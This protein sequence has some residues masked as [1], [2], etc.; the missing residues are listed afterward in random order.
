MT[1]SMRIL[2]LVAIASLGLL[3]MKSLSLTSDILSLFDPATAAWAS[4]SSAKKEKK[5]KNNDKKVDTHNAAPGP[6]LTYGEYGSSEHENGSGDLVCEGPSQAE[7]AGLSEQELNVYLTLGERNRLLNDR[8]SEI[9]TREGLLAV[10]QQQIDD[11][12]AKL[13]SLKTDIG[14]LLG[15]LDEQEEE[16]IQTLI[17]LYDAMKHKSAAQIFVGLDTNVLLQVASRIKS[18]NLAKIMAAMPPQKAGELTMA[19]A[20]RNRLPETAKDLPGFSGGEK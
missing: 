9:A 13:E 19:L 8:E 20:A 7:Q 4:S 15:Q 14:T 1:N 17:K 2:A 18:D 6:K 11:R 5:G 12:I 10:S 3:G 16:Q